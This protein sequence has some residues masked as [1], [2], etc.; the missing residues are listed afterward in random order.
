[1]F[2]A[3]QLDYF[4]VN[5]CEKRKRRTTLLLS[6]L[7]VAIYIF[8]YVFF[9]FLPHVSQILNSKETSSILQIVNSMEEVREEICLVASIIDKLLD[10][11]EALRA[12]QLLPLTRRLRSAADAIAA[13]DGTA[14]TATL[15]TL[16]PLMKAPRNVDIVGVVSKVSGGRGVRKPQGA[17]GSARSPVRQKVGPSKQS[18]APASSE[19]GAPQLHVSSEVSRSFCCSLYNILEGAVTLLR[20]SHG[21]IFVKKKDEMASIANVSQ[22]LVFPPQ[23]VHYRC[24]GNADAEVLGSSIAL[25]R[26]TEDASKKSA[27]LVFPIFACDRSC[28]SRTAI[29]TIHVERREHVFEPFN[30]TDE[31]TLYFAAMFC[32]EL[33]S[34]VPHLDWLDSFFDPTTQHIVAPFVPYK[35][36][37]LP[38]IQRSVNKCD[39]AAEAASPGNDTRPA[40]VSQLTDKIDAQGTQVLIRRESLP[41]RHSKPFAPG[42]IHMPSLLEIQAY[43][44]NLQSCWKKNMTENVELLEADRGTQQDLKA[45]R[46][47]LGSTRRQLAAANEK[48]RL[49]ELETKDYRQEYGA[50][51]SEFNTYMDKLDRLE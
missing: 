29:A 5:K 6:S 16:S 12:D 46:S 35:P 38:G 14:T 10:T 27:L 24:M 13:I 36:V 48:L 22:K 39:G 2:P 44:D 34:R 11:N 41:S 21:H 23:Q 4:S 30:N 9:F 40:I 17:L 32:G 43:V 25:N 8:P 49:Y 31:C 15:T 3:G 45:I 47:E 1:M 33:M 7:L 28:Q 26:F 19:A 42:V 20:A 50:L 37:T 18:P 51:K